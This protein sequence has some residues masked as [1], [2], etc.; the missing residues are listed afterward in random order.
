M[1][2]F[3]IPNFE[4]HFYYDFWFLNIDSDT[5]MTYTCVGLG[6]HHE[7]DASTR[8]VGTA[9]RTE[10]DE[11]KGNW[12]R[13]QKKSLHFVARPVTS[14]ASSYPLAV[15][16]SSLV[17]PFSQNNMCLILRVFL[18]YFGF[19]LFKKVFVEL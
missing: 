15:P 10:A 14:D 8:R 12:T 4:K 5:S 6:V 9:G 1:S 19:P 18:N 3:T 11:R 7:L 17:Y 2:A 13:W 16:R